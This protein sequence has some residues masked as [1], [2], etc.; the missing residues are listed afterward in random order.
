M[1]CRT[2][3]LPSRACEFRAAYPPEA[4]LHA[5]CKNRTLIAP[6]NPPWVHPARR[7]QLCSGRDPVIGFFGIRDAVDLPPSLLLHAAQFILKG[8]FFGVHQA[9]PPPLYHRVLRSLPCRPCSLPPLMLTCVYR[10]SIARVPRLPMR[11]EHFLEVPK[12]GLPR[13]VTSGQRQRRSGARRWCTVEKGLL[14]RVQQPAVGRRLRPFWCAP[15]A[16][17]RA[18]I[19]V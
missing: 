5:A 19:A 4:L 14:G 1:P 15:V 8:D 10:R 18:A 3:T 7:L 2:H 16:A 12:V 6:L 13:G 9:S 11:A 17:A